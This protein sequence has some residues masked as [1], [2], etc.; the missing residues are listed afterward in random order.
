MAAM[1][2]QLQSQID[3]L[4]RRVGQLEDQADVQA[5]K[6]ESGSLSRRIQ[7]STQSKRSESSWAKLQIAPDELGSM[8]YGHYRIGIYGHLKNS[9]QATNETKRFFYA[10][11]AILNYTSAS[12]VFNNVTQQT[13][14]RFRIEMWN[15]LLEEEAARFTA[16]MVGH[17]VYR[18]QI[19]VLPMDNV[20][21]SSRVPPKNYEIPSQWIPYQRHQY[22]T[23]SL[24]CQR[25]ADCEYLAMQMRTNAQQFDHLK[26]FFSLSSATSEQKEME[27]RIDNIARGELMAELLQRFPKVK[28]V[29]LT[30]ADE[31]RLM[32]ESLTQIIVKSFDDSIIVS[33]DSDKEIRS[34]LDNLLVSSH[35]IIADQ[36]DKK[37]ESVF[38]NED[39]FRPDK[40]AKTLNEFHQKL[41][42]DDQRKMESALE[43]A[44]KTAAKIEIGGS[45]GPIGFGSSVEAEH[46]TSK[47]DSKSLEEIKR[48]MNEGRESIEWN[49]EKFVP[50]QISLSRINLA[51]VR[52]RQSY[53]NLKVKVSYTKSMLPTGV[54]IAE[55]SGKPTVVFFFFC[56]SSPVMVLLSTSFFIYFSL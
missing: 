28:E 22:L 39:N 3:E 18:N 44:Q 41:D 31:K 29:L 37:W 26:L 8:P 11:A 27:I 56:F 2:V 16:S 20:R 12:S 40:I 15:D 4:G 10:P 21:L 9:Q 47:S 50:K 43:N 32:Q 48:L 53:Q 36:K 42:K 7:R 33:D 23:F 17:S 19:S 34:I 30:A 24:I 25:R 6:A 13:E 51:K 45:F 55:L 1:L 38:W 35:E 46:E 14:F 5:G 54:N 49:G 52:D